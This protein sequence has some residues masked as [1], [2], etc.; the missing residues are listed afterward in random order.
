M[1]PFRV[2]IIQYAEHVH[3]MQDLD[4]YLPQPSI[5]GKGYD[6]EY[7]DVRAK[8]YHEYDICITTRDELPTSIH[9]DMDGK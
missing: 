7:W 2:R 3:D 5:K 1:K 4:K 6:E 8:G 9:Y